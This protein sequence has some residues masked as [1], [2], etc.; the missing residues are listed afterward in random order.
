MDVCSEIAMWQVYFTLF[1]ALL[2]RID[3][4]A[5]DK[6][7]ELDVCLLVVALVNPLTDIGDSL[8]AHHV[9]GEEAKE[10]LDKKQEDRITEDEVAEDGIALTELEKATSTDLVSYSQVDNSNALEANLSNV[11]DINVE[12]DVKQEPTDENTYVGWTL[13]ELH[14]LISYMSYE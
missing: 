6:Q 10:E 8:F 2:L 4:F 9:V 12:D 11:E 7:L 5:D 14:S 13:R 1:I 3:S